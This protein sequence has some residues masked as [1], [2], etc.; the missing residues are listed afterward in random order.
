MLIKAD[1]LGIL[2]VYGEFLNVI[3]FNTVLKQLLSKPFS[4][5]LRRKEEHF[6][7]ITVNSH[8]CNRLSE[9]FFRNDQIFYIFYCHGN[10]F[11]DLDDLFFF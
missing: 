2:F 6:Q 1:C 10:V 5:D 7:P 11:P 8:K 9:F 3:S 4:S